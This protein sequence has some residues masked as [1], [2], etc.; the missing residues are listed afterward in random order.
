MQIQWLGL[1][2]LRIQT[3]NSVLITDP[4]ADSVGIPMPKLKA[5]LVIVSDSTSSLA[6]NTQ[7][8]SGDWFLVNEPGEYEVNETFIYG[9][10]VGSTTIYLIEDEG[11]TAAFLG[12]LDVGLT[13]EQL[14]RIEGADILFLPIGSLNKEQRTTLI[15]QIEPRIIIPY[16]YKQPKIKMDLE[17]LDV[18]LKEMG[19][20]STD[21][22]DKLIIKA[23]DLPQD[24][25]KV[26][27]LE[28]I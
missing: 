16:L 22:Q 13:D 23:K 8:I 3:K 11:V 25:T 10:P 14:E 12:K 7:R 18:F 19:I 2:A 27:L 15:S 9:I 28:A 4:F 20:K 5:D 6:N 17:P 21:A 26:V 24:E 1:A